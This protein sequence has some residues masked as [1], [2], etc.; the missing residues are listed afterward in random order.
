[1][2]TKTIPLQFHISGTQAAG[3]AATGE[4]INNPSSIRIAG[5]GNTFHALQSLVIADYKGYLFIIQAT[6][7]QTGKECG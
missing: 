7:I 6:Q 3:Y 1:M 4:V 2:E 5:V